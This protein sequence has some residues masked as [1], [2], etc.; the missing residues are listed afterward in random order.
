MASGQVILDPLLTRPM[1]VCIGIGS[2]A[3]SLGL[4]YVPILTFKNKW[5][6]GMGLGPFRIGDWDLT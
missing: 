5:E 6:L 1:V 4:G 2:D 3:F